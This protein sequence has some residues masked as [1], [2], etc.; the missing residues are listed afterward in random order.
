MLSRSTQYLMLLLWLIVTDLKLKFSTLLNYMIKHCFFF[1]ASI[2]LVFRFKSSFRNAC[3]AVTKKLRFQNVRHVDGIS[4][5]SSQLISL[6]S[7]HSL[8]FIFPFSKSSTWINLLYI[9]FY[10]R[11]F[12]QS[13][14]KHE[15]VASCTYYLIK[16][17][18][19]CWTWFKE[20][21]GFLFFLI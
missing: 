11:F 1:W 10:L 9:L 2:H 16:K 12:F 13:L 7:L 14:W 21:A 4:I 18:F 20:Q 5:T 8:I 15:W 6:F 3:K 19:R 17:R